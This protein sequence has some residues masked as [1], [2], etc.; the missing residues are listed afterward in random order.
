MYIVY[1]CIYNYMVYIYIYMY[2]LCTCMHT[3]GADMANGREKA[4]KLT[5]VRDFD[6]CTWNMSKHPKRHQLTSWTRKGF[7]EVLQVHLYIYM[8]IIVHLLSFLFSIEL[9]L[10]PAITH[11]AAVTAR[12]RQHLTVRNL[13]GRTG[14]WI[15]AFASRHQ[16]RHHALS[17]SSAGISMGKLAGFNHG[18]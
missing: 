16:V 5:N 11:H 8:Y 1:T 6:P 15:G 3:P 7:L 2:V 10:S 9:G 12:F 17:A 18:E 4:F 14:Y 13:S